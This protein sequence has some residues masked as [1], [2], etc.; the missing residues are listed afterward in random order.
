MRFVGTTEQIGDRPDE[1]NFLRK[2]AHTNT[3][4]LIP[5][6]KGAGQSILARWST[7]NQS[8]EWH[9]SNT[10]QARVQIL[11][12]RR[13]ARKYD[14]R[15]VGLGI[16]AWRGDPRTRPRNSSEFI[17]VCREVYRVNYSNSGQKPVPSSIPG[18]FEATVG[19]SSVRDEGSGPV[20]NPPYSSTPGPAASLKL[21]TLRR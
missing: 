10:N 14:F 20:P 19:I 12:K 21:I 1:C 4:E 5:R 2:I 13:G 11:G 6:G 8:Q 9:F 18:R 16:P 7:E 17:T 3:F 15:H